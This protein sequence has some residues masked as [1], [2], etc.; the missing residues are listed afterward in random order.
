MAQSIKDMTD[1]RKLTHIKYRIEFLR[2][3]IPEA[4]LIHA[5][6]QELTTFCEFQCRFSFSSKVWAY[7]IRASIQYPNEPGFLNEGSYNKLQALYQSID[8]LVTKGT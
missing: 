3:G 6:E 2:N 1:L 8:T 4:E 7:Y 5:I